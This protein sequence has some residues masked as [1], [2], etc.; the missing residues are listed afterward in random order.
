VTK[1]VTMIKINLDIVTNFRFL[2]CKFL[3]KIRIQTIAK[4]II[5]KLISLIPIKMDIKYKNTHNSIKVIT[6]RNSKKFTAIR[7]F[8]NNKIK[9]IIKCA[10]YRV[11]K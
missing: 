11:E 8:R 10:I 9:Q 7:V 5:R 4:T 1:N 6:K 3:R 2:F